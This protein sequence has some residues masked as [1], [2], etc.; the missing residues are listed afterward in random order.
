MLPD[1][2]KFIGVIGDNLHN[3]NE[4]SV[5]EIGDRGSY[6]ITCLVLG[7]PKL[8]VLHV[9]REATTES[10]QRVLLGLP[11]LIELKHPAMVVALENIIQSGNAHRVS[12]LCN[13]YING[14][15]TC[16]SSTDVG[17]KYGAVVLKN[18]QNI[19]TLD[20]REQNT[21]DTDALT[22]L[23]VSVPK[24]LH[25][26]N[27]TL[28]DFRG[29]ESLLEAAVKSLG[30]QFRLLDLV[31]MSH[32]YQSYLDD[33]IS[34]HIG[35]IIDQCR[36]IRVLRLK[37]QCEL[38]NSHES[39]ASALGIFPVDYG[40]KLS[41]A[42]FTPF[43]YLQELIID[44]ISQGNLKPAMFA[45][46]ITSPALQHLE[47]TGV[48]NFTDNVLE[49]ALKYTNHEGQQLTFTSLRKV[50]LT[51]CFAISSKLLDCV[52][53]E[54]VPLESLIVQW[55]ENVANEGLIFWHDLQ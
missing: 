31:F 28:H 1:P 49:A 48:S 44:D 20:I 6:S 38:L 17:L 11:D 42:E 37:L 47:L 18:L 21:I 9:G 12:P 26:T 50:K 25:L 5:E 51:F 39:L 55:C 27:L 16:G 13:L 22:S 41:E 23:I 34:Y 54:K 43:P 19:T 29:C 10:V 35:D 52:T 40:N 32:N 53:D 14:E 30:H 15:V 45:S 33:N 7:C 24:L 3:L 8:K 4:L 2:G 46:L 36:E